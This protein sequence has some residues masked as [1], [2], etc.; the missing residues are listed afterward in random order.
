MEPAQVPWSNVYLCTCAQM[1]LSS[2]VNDYKFWVC[3]TFP[4]VVILV[5]EPP[6]SKAVEIWACEERR[7]GEGTEEANQ[8]GWLGQETGIAKMAELCR[9][10]RWGWG[11]AQ[12]LS[13]KVKG[14]GWG[15]PARRA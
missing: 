8:E 15:M 4:F 14:R 7:R 2:G 3:R 10:Q 12:C 1:G 9:G 11:K 6:N 5:S 13:S